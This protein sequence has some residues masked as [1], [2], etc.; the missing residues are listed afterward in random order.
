MNDAAGIQIGVI[1]LSIYDANVVRSQLTSHH[2]WHDKI[3][4]EV[5]SID[6]LKLDWFDLVILSTHA[7]DYTE[8]HLVKETSI[9]MAL[10]CSRYIRV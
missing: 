1:C 8:L 9:N 10:T 3:S 4:L 7:Q 5:K 6:S 2:K